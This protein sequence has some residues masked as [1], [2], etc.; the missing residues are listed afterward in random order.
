MLRAEKGGDVMSPRPYAL[1]GAAVLAALSLVCGAA[2]AAKSY[3][4]RTGDLRG[5]AGPDLASVT[6]SNTKTKVTF[7]VR[8]TTASPLGFS[9]SEEWID[10]LIIGIDTP[11]LGRQPVPGRDWVGANFVLATHGGMN[12][13]VM[14]RVVQNGSQPPRQVASF[15]I[16]TRG[17]T[18]TFSI[19]RRT[20]GKNTA[21]FAF[22]VAAGRETTQEGQG[23]GADYAPARGSFRYV[24]AR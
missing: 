16:V 24:L 10:M 1:L 9:E 17:S 11:P 4:D 19:P 7:G 14:Q 23:G 12:T 20:L 22:Y 5:G 6:V 3:P 13:G 18:L 8:F 15:E 21:W 2:L